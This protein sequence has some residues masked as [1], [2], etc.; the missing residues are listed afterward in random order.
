[1]RQHRLTRYVPH[2]QDLRIAGACVAVSHDKAVSIDLNGGLLQPQ[3]LTCRAPADRN[4]HMRKPLDSH[5]SLPVHFDFDRIPE[6]CDT[7]NP[8]AEVNAFFQQSVQPPLQRFHQVTISTRQQSV[9]QLNDTH[10]RSE[11][12]VDCPQ[13]QANVSTTDHQQRLGHLLQLQRR[14]RI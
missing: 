13:F 12:R 9:C 8:C 3:S 10:L 6:I 5:F 4:Q 14:S 7:S 1:M 2:S 11:L